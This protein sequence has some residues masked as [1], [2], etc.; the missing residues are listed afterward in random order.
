MMPNGCALRELT[1]LP[2]RTNKQARQIAAP[3]AECQLVE[4]AMDMS[5]LSVVKG[6]IH[7]LL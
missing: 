4:A 3:H 1:I 2:R 6:L 7:Y 5:D